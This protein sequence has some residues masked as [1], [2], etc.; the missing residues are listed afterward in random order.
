MS[1][2]N[3]KSSGKGDHPYPAALKKGGDREPAIKKKDVTEPAFYCAA[4]HLGFRRKKV[5]YIS[6]ANKKGRSILSTPAKEEEEK[7]RGERKKDTA[8]LASWPKRRR[9][10][11]ALNPG[12]KKKEGGVVKREDVLGLRGGEGG[13]G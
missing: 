1:G 3:K 10:L 9:F 4:K 7:A 13:E 8:G 11:P 2:K 5:G 6:T 12:R